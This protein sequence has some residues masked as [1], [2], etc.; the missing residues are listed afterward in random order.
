[1]SDP[2]ADAASLRAAALSSLRTKRRKVDESP[3]S[4][5]R[6]LPARPDTDPSNLMLDYGNDDAES[7]L[8]TTSLEIKAMSPDTPCNEEKDN[9]LEDDAREE[10]EISDEDDSPS[11]GTPHL[12]TR[13][14]Y[15]PLASAS[16]PVA[17]TVPKG[18]FSPMSADV[19]AY[20]SRAQ[21]T[22]P[23]IDEDHVRPGL[24]SESSFWMFILYRC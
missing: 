19:H 22:A 5:T 14:T 7:I 2:V 13:T 24:S 1:M 9:V 23:V 21:G 8:P 16:S 10:G 17:V 15:H 4:P 12:A 18:P 3:T 20:A 11:S 6:H